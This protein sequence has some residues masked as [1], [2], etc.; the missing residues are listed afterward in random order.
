MHAS[1]ISQ[2]RNQ[3]YCYARGLGCDHVDAED[4]THD[5]FVRLISRNLLSN[6]AGVLESDAL[7]LYARKAAR[8]AHVDRIRRDQSLKRRG[9]QEHD[10]WSADESTP[11]QL[12]VHREVTQVWNRRLEQLADHARDRGKESLFE[13]VKNFLYPGTRCQYESR[14]SISSRQQVCRWRHWLL[15]QVRADLEAD[16]VV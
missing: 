11:A 5:V 2:L 14:S 9:P 8:N 6:H 3:L 4:L 7:T 15:A 1:A 16:Y 10:E 13:Q 12:A